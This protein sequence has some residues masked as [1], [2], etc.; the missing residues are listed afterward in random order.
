MKQRKLI[1]LKLYC[2]VLAAFTVYFLLDTFVIARVYSAEGAPNAESSQPAQTAASQS[3]PIDPQGEAETQS[4]ETQNGSS[5]QNGTANNAITKST[6]PIITANSYTDENI[7]ITITEYEAADTII[8]AADVQVSSA[9]YLKTALAKGVYGRN[10]TEDTSDIAESA[11]AIFAVNGDY[12]GAQ[13]KGYVI[14]NGVLYRGTS[15]GR[16]DLVIYEDGSFGII[17]EGQISAE[18]LIKDGAQQVLS[19]GPALIE[20]GQISVGVRSEVGKAMASNPRTAI[21]IID[22]AH[23]L[24]VVADGRTSESEGLSLY[25]LAQVMQQLGAKTAYNLDGGGSSTMYFN[26]RV[27]NNPTTNG[28]TISERRVSDIVYIGY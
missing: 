7:Q 22:E 19:F 18:Q 27:I 28:R 8:Y 24:F 14:R 1:W 2:V 6:T 12:Y 23:Y 15:A 10:V 4:G 21:G 3:E 16:E 20:N 5:K 11:G 25:Q 17:T 13:Q 26:G 9:E